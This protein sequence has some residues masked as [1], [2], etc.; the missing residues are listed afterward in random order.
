M[1]RDY[2]VDLGVPRLGTDADGGRVAE[3][4]DGRTT[5][6]VRQRGGRVWS[7]LV[8]E[9]DAASTPGDGGSR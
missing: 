4:R 3:W 5:F 1:V 8:D 7:E 2:Q 9:G 6:R